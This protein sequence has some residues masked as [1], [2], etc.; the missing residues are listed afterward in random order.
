[1]PPYSERRLIRNFRDFGP[2]SCD[3]IVTR[4]PVSREVQVVSS[5]PCLPLD[6]TDSENRSTS[7]VP[8]KPRLDLNAGGRGKHRHAG[9]SP[10]LDSGD[11][12][13]PQNDVSQELS[14]PDPWACP[15]RRPLRPVAARPQV[16]LRPRC[17]PAS[18]LCSLGSPRAPRSETGCSR[19]SGRSCS[20][21]SPPPATSNGHPAQP[22][23]E[24][25]E[26]PGSI[27]QRGGRVAWDESSGELDMPRPHEVVGDALGE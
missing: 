17:L 18:C 21:D 12:R 11:H 19:R 23:A 2:P 10:A 26:R 3:F 27:W 8:T 5:W 6:T 1:M 14:Q 4:C 15:P 20:P 7:A 24:G 9:S 16:R 25:P 13:G 22:D